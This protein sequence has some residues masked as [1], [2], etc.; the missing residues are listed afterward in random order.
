VPPN[1]RIRRLE[2]AR[3]QV[4]DEVSR[5]EQE[6]EQ[7]HAKITSGDP[8]GARAGATGERLTAFMERAR[9]L[10]EKIQEK[11]L[12]L[13]RIDRSIARERQLIGL[14]AS[15]TE[16]TPLDSPTSGTAS[17]G[18]TAR[19][20]GPSRRVGEHALKTAL[21]RTRFDDR[22]E[23]ALVEGISEGLLS[24]DVEKRR[25][26]VARIGAR[27]HPAT[28]VLLLAAD[29]PDDRVRLAALG[30]LSG[31]KGSN[32]VDVFR[33]FLR[34][35]SPALRL[36][37]LR[38]LASTNDRLLTSRD[39]VAA[40]D[41]AD[42][43]VRRAAAD[44]LSWHREE[45]KISS[46]VMYAL[47]NALHDEVEA[48]R[49]SAA[50]A[51]GAAGNDK[52]VLS[53]IRAV[54]DPSEAVRDAARQALASMVGPEV[55]SIAASAPAEK[56]VEALKAWWRIAR[57]RLRTGSDGTKEADA[58]STARDVMQTLASLKAGTAPPKQPPATA[59]R[60]PPRERAPSAPEATKA[61]PPVAVK[62]AEAAAG[63]AKAQAVAA[64]A[65]P[66]KPEQPP[67]AALPNLPTAADAPIG[68][69]PDEGAPAEGE[70]EAFEN[71]FGNAEE[72]PAGEDKEDKKEEEGAE[73]YE[74]ILGG[75]DS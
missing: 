37:A 39:L 43:S 6:L 2:L 65:A 68:D 38:G 27:P 71:L 63:V 28:Q 5:Y 47:G 74:D 64:A 10:R 17:K 26:A 50:E 55:E 16:S 15:P 1:E 59:V 70:G 45:G 62:A 49:V 41:D 30:G 33:R 8:I 19:T 61:S 3:K 14:S 18:T 73:E 11:R 54:G 13:V 29:D 22:S 53:L 67:T 12:E 75:G 60:E 56:Q 9:Q 46:Q 23:R 25:Q 58:A 36:A 40:L 66:S 57:V 34:D 24:D 7:A 35:N 51:L 21:R 32:A 4:A 52:A 69:A 44:I 48:V 72:E 20:K 31:Q 42:S